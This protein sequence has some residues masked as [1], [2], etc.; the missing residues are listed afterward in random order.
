MLFS[1]DPRRV[2]EL[3]ERQFGIFWSSP[4][5]VSAENDGGDGLQIDMFRDGRH[6]RVEVSGIPSDDLVVEVTRTA[7]Y[8]YRGPSPPGRKG[9]R[10]RLLR[11]LPLQF[12][13]EAQG[14]EAGRGTRWLQVRVPIR[15]LVPARPVSGSS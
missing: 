2:D 1:V 8:L 15:R 5:A 13:V 11:V 14:A 9:Y 6:L 7:L 3:A 10:G 4:W 12:L